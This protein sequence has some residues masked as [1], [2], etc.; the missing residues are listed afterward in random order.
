MR[1]SNVII[2]KTI[3]Y[4]AMRITLKEAYE[5]GVKNIVI[6]MFGDEAGCCH[7]QDIAKLM[8]MAYDQL[9]DILDKINWDYAYK[10]QI[11][12]L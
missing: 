3:V 5:K 11:D 8:R 2:D 12:R 6:S 9:K 7:P 10:I 4:Q 1:T